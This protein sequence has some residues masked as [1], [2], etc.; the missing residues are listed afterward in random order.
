M[1]RRDHAGVLKLSGC[2]EA[3]SV[4]A[5]SVCVHL[6]PFQN[7]I[8]STALQSTMILR[9]ASRFTPQLLPLILP[10]RLEILHFSKLFHTRGFP[11]LWYQKVKMS[12]TTARTQPQP[13]LRGIT[14]YS[15]SGQAY[16]IEEVLSDRRISPTISMGV[17]RAR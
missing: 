12:S 8:F 14:L 2:T 10:S 1:N 15:E 7:L 11:R 5:R 9:T 16:V 6:T 3:W 13:L 4:H 17:Y